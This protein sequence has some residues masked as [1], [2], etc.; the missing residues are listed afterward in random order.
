MQKKSNKR[1]LKSKL[2][3][4]NRETEKKSNIELWVVLLV[5]YEILLFA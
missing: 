3:I 1:E 4:I 2:W 5:E